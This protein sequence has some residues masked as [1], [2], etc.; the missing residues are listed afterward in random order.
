[1]KKISIILTAIA[2]LLCG[3]ATTDVAMIPPGITAKSNP[4]P[5]AAVH[6]ENYGYYLFSIIPL[7]AGNPDEPNA[8]SMTFFSDT[9]TIENNQKM[10]AEEAKALNCD[11]I[12]NVRNSTY[13]TGSFTLW[14]I[15]RQVLSSNA[16]LVKTAKPVEK[17]K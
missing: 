7:F 3:C 13:W 1:M 5:V 9:V 4:R 17:T 15:W 12:T 2:Y 14:I 16:T 10:I 6:A 8:N 11:T